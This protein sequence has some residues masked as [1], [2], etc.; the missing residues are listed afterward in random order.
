MGD[1]YF[2]LTNLLSMERSAEYFTRNEDGTLRISDAFLKPKVEHYNY[3]YYAGVHYVFDCSRPVGQR[4]TE[5]CVGGR[6]VADDD[7]FTACLSSYRA[8]G[9]GG[10]DCY[11]GCPV[12]REIGTEMSDLLLDFFHP[13]RPQPPPPPLRSLRD[14]KTPPGGQWLPGGVWYHLR[15]CRSRRRGRV[16]CPTG[17]R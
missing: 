13:D 10:Y 8:S 16:W 1:N 15:P 17:C 2:L 5:L 14:L 12:L 6:P 11:T 9:T 7:V 3:D 4:V